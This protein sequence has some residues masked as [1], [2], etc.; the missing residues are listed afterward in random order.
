MKTLIVSFLIFLS[1]CSLDNG[2]VYPDA[3]WNDGVVKNEE[4]ISDDEL[5]VFEEEEDKPNKI[6]IIE[7]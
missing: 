6:N 5:P 1:S 3:Y 7:E 2:V 4:V